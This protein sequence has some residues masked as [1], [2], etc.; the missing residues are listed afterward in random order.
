MTGI[1]AIVFAGTL[2]SMALVMFAVFGFAGGPRR[3]LRRR[4]E[5]VQVRMV[6]AVP[7]GRNGASLRRDRVTQSLL[8]KLADKLLPRP[9]ALKA[10]L[11]RTGKQISIGRYFLICTIVGL[12]FALV[13][14]GVFRLPWIAVLSVAVGAGAGLPH[15]VV[16]NLGQRR[17][18]EFTALFPEAIDLMVRGLKSGLPISECIN[19]VA[20]EISDPVGGEFRYVADRV[21]FGVM[22][23]DALWETAERLDTPEFKFFVI[24]LGVQRE[25]GGNLAETLANLSDILRRRKQM[26]LK[27][28]AMSSEARAS[29]Y[30]LG[31][32]PFLMFAILMIINY[33]YVMLLFTDPRGRMTLAVGLGML[34][35]GV[36]VMF[37]MVKFDI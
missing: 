37:K 3:R 6:R 25:T 13:A 9:K 30:I 23:E 20:E 11:A 7:T 1:T 18:G 34:F 28:K 32:L 17:L 8:D 10:R 4:A 29:A 35:A 24:S 12:I 31:S 16:G 19:A 2:A 22:L 27:I 26:K 5:N 33:D 36:V 14:L 15:I 21:R